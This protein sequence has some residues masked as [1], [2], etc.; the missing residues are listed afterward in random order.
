MSGSNSDPGFTYGEIPS[1]ITW[2]AAFSVKL[3]ADNGVTVSPLRLKV[4]TVATLPAASAVLKGA[5]ATVSDAL[6]PTYRGALTG[7]STSV[8]MVICTG[9]AWLSC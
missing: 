1:A 6:T 5:I 4:Y 7:G 8:C 3:D 2:D 9:A